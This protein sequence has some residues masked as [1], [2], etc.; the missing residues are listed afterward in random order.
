[1]KK[2]FAV[3]I[4]AVSLSQLAVAQ[5][6][7][8]PPGKTTTAKLATC[9]ASQRA[10]IDSLTAVLK[11]REAA[12]YQIRLALDDIYR[13]LPPDGRTVQ[14]YVASAVAAAT[15]GVTGG[16]APVISDGVLYVPRRIVIGGPCKYKDADSQ[17]QICGQRDANIH[18]ESN[19]NAA[20]WQNPAV[21][22]GLW[23]LSADGGMRVIQNMYSS[24]NGVEGTDMGSGAKYW[25]AMKTFS[26]PTRPT[27]SVGFDSMA[28][29]S[30]N[31][32]KPGEPSLGTQRIVLRTDET[33]KV[34]YFTTWAEGWKV[35]FRGSTDGCK[36]CENIRWAVP[37]Q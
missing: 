31:G 4:L 5:S 14:A 22:V 2:L 27:G 13:K 34:V 1:M 36:W 23:S 32:Q 7:C 19:L 20:W 10:V 26:D 25:N 33:A 18:V 6:A 9:A 12:D 21:H 35:Q 15:G 30:W 8:P 3:V 24:V 17:L 37:Y 28:E 16:S 11:A 29:W